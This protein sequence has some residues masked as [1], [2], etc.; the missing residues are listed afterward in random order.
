MKWL[1]IQKIAQ[2]VTHGKQKV[3]AYWN[4]PLKS[5]ARA[6]LD[7]PINYT[8]KLKGVTSEDRGS[9]QNQLETFRIY[10]QGLYKS[11]HIGGKELSDVLGKIELPQ[12]LIDHALLMDT[13]I[14]SA[15]IEEAI[16]AL[17]LNTAP[18]LD[19]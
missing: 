19:G 7:K 16:V 17:K 12:L 3:F 5:L 2:E 8:P 6:L 9:T 15:E 4:K 13:H 14:T 10:S 1:D 18:G 11:E